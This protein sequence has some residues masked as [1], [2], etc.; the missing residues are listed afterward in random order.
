MA[1]AA[2]G[3]PQETGANVTGP[4]GGS[5]RRPQALS[6]IAAG[7]AAIMLLGAAGYYLVGPGRRSR[8]T[9]T[10]G[11]TAAAQVERLL[12]MVPQE[13]LALT[14]PPPTPQAL[15]RGAQVY[16]LYCATCHGERG[17]GKGPAA[18]VFRPVPV[19]FTDVAFASIPHGASFYIVQKG[20]PGTGMA[21]WRGALSDDDTW[22][23]ILYIYGSF[24]DRSSSSPP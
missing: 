8:T 2:N 4:P 5:R 24:V 9:P 18:R 22:A 1:T 19:D 14:P 7:V 12:G 16:R 17:D 11:E 10:P 20:S 21:P 15:E 6:W 23:V 13:Y 3:S